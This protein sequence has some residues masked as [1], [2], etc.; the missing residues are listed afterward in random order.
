MNETLRLIKERY[1]CRDFD[2]QMPTEE[3][4]QAVALAAVQA[5]SGMNRQGWQI[6][7]VRDEALIADMEKEG[8]SL[9][10]SMDK[11]T[12]ERILSRGGH[13]F[14][15]APCMVMIAVKQAQPRGAELVDLGIA[16]QNA[17]LAATSLGLASLH[18]G[19][20]GLAFAGEREAEFKARLSFPEGYE[21]GLAVLLG[22]A[23]T[24]SVPHTPDMDKITYVD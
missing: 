10:E 9:L 22:T 1:S 2:K 5:P 16:A 21:C 13:M 12:F 8:M 4:L 19:L 11:K 24:L 14:Y 17:V 23:K 18:C 15:H 7:V 6:I 20:A 3:Q